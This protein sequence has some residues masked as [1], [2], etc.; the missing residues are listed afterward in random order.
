MD[1][2]MN[3]YPHYS[4]SPLRI[5][6]TVLNCVA[7]FT[8]IFSIIGFIDYEKIGEYVNP[9]YDFSTFKKPQSAV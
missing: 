2:N 7:T 1:V 5:I 6:R 3:I 8:K 4:Q 9:L